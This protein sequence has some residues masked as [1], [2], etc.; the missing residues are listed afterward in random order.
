MGDSQLVT[1]AQA[2]RLVGRARQTL[3]RD[4]ISTG[5]LSATV[6]HDKKQKL[7]A[8]SELIRVFGELKTDSATVSTRQQETTGDSRGNSREVEELRQEN[9][10]LR[11]SLRD[12][13]ALLES[14]EQNLA[15]LRLAL[16][17]LQD[18]TK[19]AINDGRQLTD[20][21]AKELVQKLAEIER[22]KPKKKKKK[23]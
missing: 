3:Y 17:L 23:A 16:R 4:Y 8:I 9:Q 22:T 21:P 5:K 14:R 1:V 10:R 18:K 20:N 19:H 15:D 6:S 11:D 7:V 13:D 12:K 2:A